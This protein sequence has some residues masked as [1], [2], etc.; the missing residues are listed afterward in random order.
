MTN[1]AGQLLLVGIPGPELD[2]DTAAL[3]RRVQPGGT[4]C[5]S[6]RATLDERHATRGRGNA[7][8]LAITGQF[9]SP[10]TSDWHDPQT[11]AT[12]DLCLSCKACKSECPSNV[13]ISKLKAEFAAQGF[14]KAGRIPWRTRVIGRVRQGS[15][16]GSRLW[17]LANL[18]LGFGPIRRA[19]LG[20]LG[21][22]TD[23]TL[24]TYGP[25]VHRWL[26]RRGSKAATGAPTVLLFPD[27]FSNFGET[28]LG[29]LAVE[30]L[31]AF[32]YRVVMP[33][34]GCCGR[35]LISVGM[36]AEAC[37][38]VSR[39]ATALL[40]AVKRE[41]A[42]AVLGLEPSCVSAIKDDWIDLRTAVDRDALRALAAR[43]FLVEVMGR[44]SAAIALKAPVA[45]GVT[46][47]RSGS[48]GG[49]L[50]APARAA[51]ARKASGG[52][53]PTI[54]SVASGRSSYGPAT[55]AG[56]GGR[57]RRAA[58]GLASANSRMK[59][60]RSTPWKW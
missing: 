7:L 9:G 10:G 21:F 34:V 44:N 15:R 3:L 5:P 14:A 46:T 49:R 2:A 39:T 56:P 27:C 16:M 31:E 12:L 42:V 37:G 43:T 22:H 6:Y 11:K 19:L 36:L 45:P 60:S 26:A 35:S 40:E 41:N 50:G 24:P 48:I 59:S 25:A 23:R 58:F 17:P 54:V 51:S 28:D 8:R 13:D 52:C 4:M 32:G 53:L 57:V 29:R 20:A 38:T 47:T 1:D 33:D 18:A 55:V 30:L